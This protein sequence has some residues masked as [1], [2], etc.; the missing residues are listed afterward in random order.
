MSEKNKI[1]QKEKKKLENLFENVD[2]TKKQLVQG[3]IEDAAFLFA[4]NQEIKNVLSE[5][6]MV[7]VHPENKSLQKAVPAAAQ[8]LKNVNSYANVIKTLN[9][10]FGK[11][12]IDDD[13]GLDE[14]E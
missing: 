8:Y 11:N 9:S 7:R 10:I 4:E 3:L 5:I 13:D 6:G 1:F 2:E 14:Y 12:I